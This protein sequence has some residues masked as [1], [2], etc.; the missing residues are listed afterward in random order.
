MRGEPLTAETKKMMI[1]I[2]MRTI[3]VINAD[4]SFLCMPGFYHYAFAL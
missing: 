4:A 1:M 3:I 2:M